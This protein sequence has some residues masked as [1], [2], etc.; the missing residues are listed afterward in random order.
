MNLVIR[1]PRDLA[2]GLL[3]AAFGL[4]AVVISRKYGL[5]TGVRMG[6]AYFPTVVGGM[7]VTIGLASI[8]RSLVT[9]GEAIG[10]VAWKPLL[11]V[12]VATVL[13]GALLRPAGLIVSLAVLI[14]ASAAASIRFR[15]ELQA[16]ALMVAL[17]A[18][19]AGIFVWGLGLSIPLVGYWLHR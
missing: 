15:L 13:F 10:S 5:G 17:I 12:T 2:A 4:A 9:S 11:L 1:S 19:C 18:A 6:P 16:L 8:A 3:Y 14:L 7:L